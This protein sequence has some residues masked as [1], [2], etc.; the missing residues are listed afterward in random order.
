MLFS[1]SVKCFQG[2]ANNAFCPLLEEMSK[3]TT[4]AAECGSADGIDPEVSTH[5]AAHLASAVQWT[6]PESGPEPH[7]TWK[8]GF[9]SVF[10]FSSSNPTLSVMYPYAT[11]VV[12]KWED[13]VGD[14]DI[15]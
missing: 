8:Q 13:I 6:K 3:R 4:W 12:V 14:E 7:A 10:S 11:D 9:H 2:G 5:S 15:A 1:L